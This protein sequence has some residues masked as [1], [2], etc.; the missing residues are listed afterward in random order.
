MT[1]PV[2]PTTLPCVSR[3]DGYALNSEAALIRTPFEAGNARQR[4]WNLM[5]PTQIQLGW[6]AAN[7][8]LQPL[9]AWLNTYGYD[10]FQLTT[11]GID[12]SAAGVIAVPIDV[13]LTS[14]LQVSLIQ[15]HR[16]NW[17][18]VLATAI[19]LPAAG[20]LISVAEDV[21]VTE[22]TSIRTTEDGDERV[23]EEG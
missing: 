4:R 1:I 9:F 15:F 11:A 2:Y 16:Q 14:D 8:Q 19:Y 3:I 10:W 18:T 22:D 21:R 23:I 5:L 7:D 6:R 13:R 17:W 20:A 12:S